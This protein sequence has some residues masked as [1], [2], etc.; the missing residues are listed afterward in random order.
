MSA[1]THQARTVVTTSWDDGHVLDERLAAVLRRYQLPGTF[2]IA[3]RNLEFPV[4][5]RL[6]D[7]GISE[8]AQQFE[9]G[10]HTLTHRR[11]PQLDL[12]TARAEIED[13]KAHLERIT[14]KPVHS[15][16]YPRGE[17]RPEHVRLVAQAGFRFARTVRRLALRP[18][19][20]PLETPTTIHAYQHLR[21]VPIAGR[22]ARWRPRRVI[23]LWR[24]WDDLAVDM[25]DTALADGGVFHLWGHSWEIDR[26]QGWQRLERVCEYISRRAGVRYV[27]NGA[28][29]DGGPSAHAR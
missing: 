6:D 2:Y 13:G 22:V 1:A 12:P 10:G 9:I 27:D 26:D 8:L 11:L 17:Y 20:R 4:A 25:F 23:R 18:G 16:C 15:F 28:L 29:H 21:D 5:D 19:H 3:P 24:N 7:H 14:R